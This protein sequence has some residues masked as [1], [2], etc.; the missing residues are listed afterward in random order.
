MQAVQPDCGVV[1]SQVVAPKAAGGGGGG[2][3]AGGTEAAA[4]HLATSASQ[5]VL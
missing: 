3:G 2:A 4:L 5:S 1:D